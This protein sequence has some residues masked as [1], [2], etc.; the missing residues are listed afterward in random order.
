MKKSPSEIKLN[1][2]FWA[3]LFYRFIY[4]ISIGSIIGNLT[5][6]E[7]DVFMWMCMCIL[8]SI[9]ICN[10]VLYVVSATALPKHQAG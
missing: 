4:L 7:R 1:V 5:L 9:C 3:S 6:N 8:V 2:R 10:Q